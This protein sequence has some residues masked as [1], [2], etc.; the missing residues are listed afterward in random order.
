MGVSDDYRVPAARSGGPLHCRSQGR[1]DTCDPANRPVI[2]ATA[3]CVPDRVWV[4]RSIA[5]RDDD[6][7]F[8]CLLVLGQF[9]LSP[10]STPS[11]SICSPAGWLFPA[12]ALAAPGLPQ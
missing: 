7:L 10:A 1:G 8:P 5:A 9:W 4:G 12:A 2:Y 11:I 3:L 6:R